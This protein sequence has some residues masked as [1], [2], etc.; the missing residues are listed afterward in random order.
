M[1]SR[2]RVLA[3]IRHKNPDRT[4]MDFGGCALSGATPQFLK[5]MRDILGYSLPPDRDED[6]WWVDES[7][8]KYLNVDLR[9]VPQEP[10]LAILKDLDG[11]EY[12]KRLAE[13]E[14]KQLETPPSTKIEKKLPPL[15]SKTLE[16]FQAM[17][18]DLALPPRY[19]DWVIQTA[20]DYR[21]R[22][23]ATSIWVDWRGF[24][25]GS[26][27]QR[28][29]DQI[30]MDLLV[31]QDLI[32][33]W[34]DL[35]LVEKLHLIDVLV[36]PLAPYI[37]ILCFGDDWGMQDRLFM[38]PDL[39]REM[40]KPYVQKQYD[41]VHAVA[42]DSFIFHHSCG[43]VT[44]IM[45][46]I[47]E[48]G[49]DILNPIQPGAAGMTPENLKKLGNGRLCFHGGIDLQNLLPFGTP[50][51]VTAEVKNRIATFGPSGGYICAAAH[52]LPDDVP[53]E[54]I[55]ALYKAAK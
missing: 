5:K 51:E 11:A 17:K 46:D 23:Y 21:A 13:K 26:C 20:K 30:A 1:N 34:F 2:D 8:Q 10:P 12:Q 47:M 37:D 45:P 40:I 44:S 42:P 55:L 9:L 16:D 27:W 28:G 24:F 36:K 54:N 48:M 6:G 15:A 7:I 19:L 52:T 39:F 32:R 18:P 4:P 3:A 41:H 29:Y 25:E 35:R 31:E 14:K 53:P 38:S 33:T 43:S 49:I 22:G 50:S